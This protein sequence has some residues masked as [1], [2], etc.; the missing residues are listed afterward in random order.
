VPIE[1]T[2]GKVLGEIEPLTAPS[3]N[4]FHIS[5]SRTGKQLAYVQRTKYP[6]I[7]RVGFDP[8]RETTVGQP[9]PVTHG[10]RGGAG[11]TGS[12]D[13]EW[14]AFVGSGKGDDIFVVRKDGSGLR[15]L[16]DDVFIDR[17][18]MWS[19]DGNFIAFHSNRSGKFEI[20]SI[21]PDGSD[22]RQLTYTQRSITHAVFSP[23]GKRMVYSLM[24]GTPSIVETAKPWSGQSPQALPTLKDSGTWFEAANWSPDGRKLAGFQVRADGI[25][26]GIGIYSLDTGEYSR[27]SDFADDPFW[28]KD[29]RRLIFT[30]GIPRD[31]SIYLVDSQTRKIHEILSVAPNDMIVSAVSLDNRWIYYNVEVTEADI[32]LATL[33]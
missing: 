10:S 8:Q 2:S 4:A 16:T 31:S 14:I 17:R 7:W 9:I 6:N 11:A 24:N 15:Q 21:R 13:G 20:W 29:S 18:P 28:L 32:W 25:F 1:E 12:P 22:L 26:N 27:I 33:P 3:T 19:P 30:H 5:F 23:D